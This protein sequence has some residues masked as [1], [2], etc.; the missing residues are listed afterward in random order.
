M[1]SEKRGLGRGGSPQREEGMDRRNGSRGGK[2]VTRGNQEPVGREVENV[3]DALRRIEMG[4]VSDQRELDRR[5]VTGLVA[6]V[7][8][9]VEVGVNNGH[10]VYN[11]TVL[12]QRDIGIV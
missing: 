2:A 7:A 10:P 12:K 4:I 5:V 3:G 6:V 9:A 11:V 8:F 1:K